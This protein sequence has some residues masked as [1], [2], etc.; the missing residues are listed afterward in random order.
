MLAHYFAPMVDLSSK[1]IGICGKNN[2][3]L[4]I[5]GVFAA[6]AFSKMHCDIFDRKIIQNHGEY[7]FKLLNVLNCKYGS[8]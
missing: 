8:E 6:G 3:N 4:N 5:A 1:L 7:D 2:E